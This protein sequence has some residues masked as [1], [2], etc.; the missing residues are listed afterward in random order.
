MSTEDTDDNKVTVGKYELNAGA[1]N[2]NY[3]DAY[4]C[5]KCETF[6]VEL[7]TPSW[8]G[9]DADWMYECGN[10]GNIALE[11]YYEEIEEDE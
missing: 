6:D 11:H 3:R 8:L 2:D 9:D 5:P 7:N 1:L 4:A 10:C